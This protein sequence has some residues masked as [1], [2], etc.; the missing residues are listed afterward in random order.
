MAKHLC[1]EER[2]EMALLLSHGHSFGFIAKAL[3]RAKSTIYSEARRNT[4]PGAHYRAAPAEDLAR[5]RAQ[6]PRTT[7]KMQDAPL[8]EYVQEKLAHKWSPEQI[9]GRIARDFPQR[10]SM[11][12]SHE[13][14]YKWI[15]ERKKAGDEWHSHLRQAHKK[16][17]RRWRR[18]RETRGKIRGR[19]SI[20]ERPS[21]VDSRRF[22][23]DWEGDSLVGMGR[24]SSVA[25]WVERKCRYTCLA[26][27]E[28]TGPAVFNKRV[29]QRFSS[30][31]ELP[32]RTVTVDNGREFT[33]HAALSV[34]WHAP[35]Y[36]AHPYHSWERGLNENTNGLLRQFYP[37][38]TD[39][40]QVSRADIAE[41]ERLL[42][43]RPRKCLQYRTPEEAMA[44][45]LASRR[46]D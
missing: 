7:R 16:R 31:P 18:S 9:A 26:L 2:A 42:N 11:R 39:F 15:W 28:G 21:S 25:T 22:V 6:K 41:K 44:R 17:G 23:G 27:V 5:Q 24:K 45:A 35:I 30:Q 19:T 13:T 10:T 43:T 32:I 38:G 1:Y 46:S 29:L 33:A 14:I 20:D 8:R 12:I 4:S 3:G 37:K 36:F 40:R 34:A